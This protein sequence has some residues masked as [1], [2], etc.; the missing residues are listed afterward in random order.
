[1]LQITAASGSDK[2]KSKYTLKGKSTCAIF[3]IS[4]KRI[5]YINRFEKNIKNN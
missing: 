3:K 4:A 1:V 5:E 2:R